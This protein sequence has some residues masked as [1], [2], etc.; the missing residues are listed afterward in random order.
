MTAD[1]SQ[2]LA[3][4]AVNAALNTTLSEGV[5]AERQMFYSLFATDDQSEGM[6]AFL[7]KRSAHFK[8]R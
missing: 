3:K 1:V 5:R 4:A 6:T 8:H 7:E 2:S